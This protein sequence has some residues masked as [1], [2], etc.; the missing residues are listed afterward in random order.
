M[1][2]A[3]LYT[4]KLVPNT[5]E[6][7][8]QFAQ[9]LTREAA[10]C[11]TLNHQAIQRVIDFFEHDK[12]LVLVLEHIEGTTLERLSSYLGQ[13]KNP[14]S[15]GAKAYIGR[16]VASAL[17]HAHA[18]RDENGK[19]M[20]IVHRG[21][22]PEHVLVGWDGQVR[23]TGFGL[24]KILGRSPDTV[25]ANRNM[26]PGYRAPEQL[27]GE[28][29]TPK[30]DVYGLGLL[31]WAL[32]SGQTP[33]AKGIKPPKLA[34]VRGDLLKAVATAIDAAL[35]TSVDKRPA[36]CREIEM[37]L[38]MVPGIESG[39]EELCDKLDGLR[40]TKPNPD[41]AARPSIP[42]ATR[43]RI[44]L[45]SIRPSQP[46]ISTKERLSTFPPAPPQSVRPMGSLPPILFDDVQPKS[47]YPLLKALAD[48]VP[49]DGGIPKAPRLPQVE[50]PPASSP[51]AQ[52]ER[53]PRSGAPKLAVAA[54]LELDARGQKPRTEWMAS[55]PDE[56]AFDKLFDEATSRTPAELEAAG[57]GRGAD[58]PGPTAAPKSRRRLESA[59][60]VLHNVASLTPPTKNA[61]N[62]NTP[63]AP[64][65][66]GPP[67]TAKPVR[68]GPAP[69]VAAPKLK[70]GFARPP[71]PPGNEQKR[72]SII[73]LAVVFGLVAIGV[74]LLMSSFFDKPSP[75]TNTTTSASASAKI[76]P[77][78]ASAK[79]SITAT[80]APNPAIPTMSATSETPAP[81]LPYGQGYL[82]VV[83]PDDATVYVSGRKLG[84]TNT[85]LQNRCGRYFVRVA[86]TSDG[87]YPEWLSAGQPVAIPC[88]DS[89]RVEIP[90]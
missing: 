56:E 3:R 81:P 71:V 55:V 30:A 8:A 86:K 2:F 23:L 33:S 17:V 60:T 45:Q 4:L 38:G 26:A 47:V 40:E 85:R 9:E 76:A 68:F 12:D 78:V 1:G 87:P 89:I 6:G 50:V 73:V 18:A 10:I 54:P 43:P 64:P 74:A 46:A 48:K 42:S 25:V 53:A 57:I 79:P 15:D 32:F 88:Q 58:E 90:R 61:T 28:T 24:G 22:H 41:S 49:K 7:D 44:A 75:S 59:D 51:G 70:R 31:M 13:K 77:P 36:S 16:E 34:T 27:R 69:A 65:P 67:P 62:E 80:T 11:S 82:T 83:F 37:A 14:L 72:P 21:L 63:L 39:R 66:L 19:P 29:V 35:E 52:S 5:G 84:K 20:P